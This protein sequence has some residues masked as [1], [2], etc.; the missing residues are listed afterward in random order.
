MCAAASSSAAPLL[1]TEEL[2]ATLLRELNVTG[3]LRAARA[4]LHFR[5][6]ECAPWLTLMDVLRPLMNE[7]QYDNSGMIAWLLVSASV[8]AAPFVGHYAAYVDHYLK[9][10]LRMWIHTSLA[11]RVERLLTFFSHR[12]C[13]SRAHH[14][15]LIGV[16]GSFLQQQAAPAA[17][18]VATPKRALEVPDDGRASV[19]D[20]KRVAVAASPRAGP[21][22]I[23][24]VA[25]ISA[26]PPAVSPHNKSAAASSAAALPLAL[27]VAQQ[28]VRHLC[29]VCENA[30]AEM[31]AVPCGC[32]SVC[33]ACS[34]ALR[35]Q[36]A[37]CMRCQQRVYSF[38]KV[39]LAGVEEPAAPVAAPA[40]PKPAVSAAALSAAL[41]PGPRFAPPL[42]MH[43]A[44]ASSVTPPKPAAPAPAP[45][46]A[47]T[48]PK[49][50]ALVSGAAR[51]CVCGKCPTRATSVATVILDDVEEP[52]VHEINVRAL[53]GKI[54]T[55]KGALTD[56][57]YNIK[58]KLAAVSGIPEAQQRLIYAGK[59]LDDGHTLLHYNV[60]HPVT[61]HL[62]Q[63]LRGD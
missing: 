37:A 44:T 54:Y 48:P 62:V 5:D 49:Y 42:V 33:L 63:A 58:S 51:P 23:P 52:A 29:R 2:R 60:E 7:P 10:A 43:K 11:T 53:S 22:F 17:A 14:V 55:I 12:D 9:P 26:R 50:A 25:P 40:T 32:Q 36:A 41:A 28:A 56:T 57:G 19:P 38:V 45:A 4:M 39:T 59:S 16:L 27:P 13:Q 20:A 47:P 3:L 61:L 6:L 30:P 46:P 18:A 35:A 34:D 31:V 21:I 1:T 24:P 8:S 15:R